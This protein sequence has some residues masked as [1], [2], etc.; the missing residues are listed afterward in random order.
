MGP[1]YDPEA[2]RAFVQKHVN[3]QNMI[4]E[5]LGHIT[6]FP[7][8]AGTEGSYVLGEW[9]QEIF[10]TAELEEVNMERFDVYMNYPRSIGRKLAIVE[11][12][13][14]GWEATIEEENEETAVFHGHS[15]AGDVKGPL[16][17]ANYGSRD[18]FAKLKDEG[19][20][21]RG[22][23]VLMRYYGTQGDAGLKVKAAEMAGAVGAVLFS[24]PADIGYMMG[25][26]FPEGRFLP[27]DGVQRASV[28]MQSFVVGDM[29]SP[30]WASTPG[31]KNRLDKKKSTGLNTIPSLPISWNDAQ[32]LL[33][34]IRA[35]GKQIPDWKGDSRTDFW[36]GSKNSPV[37][38]LRNEQDEETRQG[39]YNVLGKITG[40]EQPEKK[41]IVGSHRDAWC[42]GAGESGTGTAIMLD[43][44][45]I[46]GELRH[47]NWRPLR[48]I[49]FASWDSAAFNLEGS[50]EHVENRIDELRQ[51]GISYVNLDAAI[52]GTNFTV[53]GSSILRRPIF[54]A[55]NRVGD[56]ST[57]DENTKTV[58]EVWDGVGNKLRTP[59]GHRD[60]LPFHS[61][62]GMSALDISFSSEDPYAFGSCYDRYESIATTDNGFR[63]HRVLGEIFALI[64]LE[65]SDRPML[66]FDIQA[67]SDELRALANTVAPYAEDHNVHGLDMTPLTDSIALVATAAKEV[68]EL[69]EMWTRHVFNH[70]GFEGHRHSLMRLN[71]NDRLAKFEKGLLDLSDGGGLKDRK[72]YKHTVFAPQKWDSTKGAVFP[73]V[74]DAIDEGDQKEAQFQIQVV[75]DKLR[76]AAAGLRQPP[77][78]RPDD[79]Q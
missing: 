33:L 20:D 26:T 66:P 21:V 18:D 50:T 16:I 72:Q 58:K 57:H 36:T 64:I 29:L 2:L 8:L 59:A 34:S 78:E 69:E 77:G 75:A 10:K 60:T 37:V 51:D 43:V 11:G 32:H 62:A 65:L 17:Y 13:D 63:Y 14:S 25:P 23:V 3:N 39:I 79:G 71:H 54:E 38:N 31:E 68:N 55:A 67:F 47:L 56:P 76:D 45:R 12:T 15:A 41:I 53:Q 61:F 49:E 27:E 40:W 74:I 73:G 24:A 35:L 42:L 46:F 52:T 22:A 6:E 30:G 70:G 7:H 28:G 4:Q 9:I 44:I 48:T 5:Y 19:I 1:M